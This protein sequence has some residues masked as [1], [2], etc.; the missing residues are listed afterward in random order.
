VLLP[1]RYLVSAVFIVLSGVSGLAG[2]VFIAK[3]ARARP[4]VAGAALI[5]LGA[6]LIPASNIALLTGWILDID[7][8][9][10]EDI[11]ATL[12]ACGCAV[13]AYSFF[14]LRSR[15]KAPAVSLP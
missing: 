11:G 8:N 3:E 12:A 10:Y 1:P 14:V 13:A 9:I 15:A 2:A 4:L 7:K 6:L 5:A